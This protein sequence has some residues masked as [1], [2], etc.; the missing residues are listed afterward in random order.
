MAS[1]VSRIA[2][3]AAI[4]SGFTTTPVT[5]RWSTT[6]GNT[7]RS[8]TYTGTG[9][10][11]ATARFTAA[12][13]ASNPAGLGAPIKL[14]MLTGTTPAITQTA[15]IKVTGLNS[16]NTNWWEWVSHAK[17]TAYTQAMKLSGG[18]FKIKYK[19]AGGMRAFAE[20]YDSAGVRQASTQIAT[21]ASAGGGSLSVTV[22]V[23][24]TKAITVPA[25]GYAV[26]RIQGRGN[27]SRS[28]MTM[29]LGQTANGGMLWSP[30]EAPAITGPAA[31]GAV[32][33][34]SDIAAATAHVGKIQAQATFRNASG[35][36]YPDGIMVTAYLASDWASGTA[37]PVGSA[38]IAGGAG[39]VAIDVPTTA[40][41]V[42]VC[43][44]LAAG[45]GNEVAMTKAVTPTVI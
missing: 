24:T 18:Q 23:P 44:P 37:S 43:D 9:A 41:V 10:N 29:M 11:I 19:R 32:V 42:L 12:A 28:K 33:D 31:S 15:K 1:Y 38:A 45:I 6:G 27:T 30:T 26:V 35:T 34:G 7:G 21:G 2:A 20:A 25:G 17:P 36:P 22:A 8:T 4:F 40:D 5:N 14:K 39:A 3:S 13:V 16:T